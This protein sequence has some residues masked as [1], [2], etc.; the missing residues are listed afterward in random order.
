M[1]NA[2]R[3]L[4]QGKIRAAINEY[5]RVVENDPKD[6]STLNILGDLY[7]KNSDKQ[8]A[9][10]C[11]TLVA[12]HYNT[13]GFSHKA[14]AVYNKISRIEPTS[15]AVSAKLAELYQSKGSIAEARQ[16]YKILAD[17]YQ[18]KGQKLEALAIWKQIAELDPNNTEIYLKIAENYCQENQFEEAVQPF[19]EAGLRFLKQEKFELAINA[20]TRALEIKNNDL[21]ALKGLVKAQ[22]GLGNADEAASTLEE[23][24]TDQPENHE[25]FYLLA[26]CYLE[27]NNAPKAESIIIKLFEREPA[28]HLKFLELV[29]LYLKSGDLE[30][31]TRSLSIPAENLLVNGQTEELFGWV[32]EILARNPEQVEALRLLTRYYDWKHNTEEMQQ[33]LERLA[34][35]ARLNEAF[36]DEHYALTQLLALSPQ[37]NDYAERLL[38]LSTAHGFQQDFSTNQ[39]NAFSD[40]T[41]A[42]FSNFENSS[43]PASESFT[44]TS[45]APDGEFNQFDSTEHQNSYEFET[46]GYSHAEA[47]NETKDFAFY[48][49]QP[50]ETSNESAFEFNSEQSFEETNNYT[51]GENNFDS[52]THLQKEIEGIEFYIEQG[53]FD[54]ASYSLDEV[55]TKFGNLAEIADLRNRI[56]AGLTAAPL[57]VPQET[58]INPTEQIQENVFY[59]GNTET[60]S[61]ETLTGAALFDE[62]KSELEAE[63]NEKALINDTYETHFH[64]GTAYKEMGL[65]EKAIKEFQMAINLV[66]AN[67]GTRRFFRC[68][69]TLGH[70]FIEKQMPKAAVKWFL[71]DLE[72]E[73]LSVE[74]RHAILYD[75]GHAFDA[76]G[77]KEKAAD[78]FEQLY[79]EDVEYRD[80]SE[81]LERL[82]LQ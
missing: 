62:L 11:F 1:R 68:A 34:E 75:L 6:Y 40:S 65:L 10:G 32:T 81:R 71:R 64:M 8:Q 49:A 66:G 23:L 35:A 56:R 9:V 44:H 31:A 74:E 70:C 54:L 52:A 14:I 33:A 4:S 16:H 18:Q 3:F 69:N 29:K 72:V 43:E 50:I 26:D 17:H 53:Y 77:E 22:I 79:S 7:A 2:E 82:Q 60:V 12:E 73:D 57:E 37:E 27:M 25:I 51:P 80:V 61:N 28:N 47:A 59:E 21:R 20:F 78:Y 76:S 46:N 15:I 19:V 30:A 55:E 67:D 24:L 39:P 36:A 48:D 5:Q 42:G 13:Q 38:E 41:E 45:N 58:L 63:E